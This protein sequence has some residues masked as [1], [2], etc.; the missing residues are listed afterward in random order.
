MKLKPNKNRIKED[1]EQLAASID[2]NFKGYTRLA[3]SK[4][5]QQATQYLEAKL[6][7]EAGM[8]V[9]MDSVGNLI[10]RKDGLG[11]DFPSILTGS[12]LDTVKEGGKYDGVIGVV[13]A[14]EI[15]RC[16][17][18]ADIQLNHPLEVVAFLAEEP[19]PFGMS[20][21]GSRGMTGHLKQNALVQAKNG[22]GQSLD[23]AIKEFGGDPERLDSAVKKAGS[24]KAFIEVHIEQ[25]PVLFNRG[26]TIGIVNSIV[27]IY[28]GEIF[29][30]GE[31]NHAGTTP[32]YLRKDA[33]VAAAN[34]ITSADQMGRSI[35]D[36]VLTVGEL[37]MQ[38]NASNVIPGEVKLGLEL[39]SVNESDIKAVIERIE[40]VL[41]SQSQESKVEINHRFWLSS[42]KVTFPD[43][44]VEQAKM[45]CK[46]IGCD[47][48]EMGSGAGH[49]AS[50]LA[51]IAPAVM[52]F[53][54]SQNGKSHC[55]DE[56]SSL[57]D[58]TKGVEVLGQMILQLDLS[59]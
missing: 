7:D 27:S 2:P 18:D 44:M 39:R 9:Q 57:E 54:P 30:R 46:R 16:L 8:S 45:A 49:D 50:Y 43:F 34:I 36:L 41:L 23:M 59:A 55:P 22:A 24:I 37:S 15:A 52:I 53:V 35:K 28:R 56:F 33:L 11:K 51:E 6:K 31:N 12:H 47:F 32:M 48:L 10:G 20:T 5:H 40:D 13:G 4:Y 19:S 17:K 21:I 3:F 29:V 42:P 25:G 58:I 26:F 38:P 14:L 1:I